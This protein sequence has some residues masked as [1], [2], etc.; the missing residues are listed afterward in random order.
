LQAEIASLTQQLNSTREQIRD[1]ERRERDA[2]TLETI[3]RLRAERLTL[4]GNIIQ[5]SSTIASLSQTL[6]TLQERTNS[7]DIIEYAQPP[8]AST[9]ASTTII[10]GLGFIVGAMLAG[11]AVLLLDELDQTM[12][13]SGRVK[14]YTGLPVLSMVRAFN[15][16]R[17]AS[18]RWL[19]AVDSPL[20][21]AADAYRLLQGRLLY[22]D[23]EPSYEYIFTSARQG[24]GKS[25]TAANLAVTLASAGFRVAMI[26]VNLRDPVQHLIFGVENDGGL[27]KLLALNPDEPGQT[28]TSLRPHLD[29]LLKR[30]KY[31]NLFVIP[32]GTLADDASISHMMFRLNHLAR[33][34][35]LL[36]GQYGIDAFVFDTAPSLSS[37]ESLVLAGA[38]PSEII[39]VVEA[40]RTRREDAQEAIE[41]FSN[42]GSQVKGVVLNKV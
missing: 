7:L 6:A 16:P 42:T 32:R 19:V 9:G 33:W 38:L 21:P 2:Y 25:I 30:T 34:I 12:K 18:P 24:E 11:G 3:E 5:V 40:G 13:S 1:V 23:R 36:R 35:D 29:A 4:N 27:V 8:G 37:S 28:D 20:S 41:Q 17:E 26:D 10:A 31:E 14:R 22:V 15:A 39:M